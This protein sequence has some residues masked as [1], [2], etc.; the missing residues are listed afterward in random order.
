MSFVDDILRRQKELEKEH[1]HYFSPMV[2]DMFSVI[3]RQGTTRT[4]LERMKR[5]LNFL[6]GVVDYF[7]SSL[8][9]PDDKPATDDE[10]KENDQ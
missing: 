3:L 5:E 6:I 1:T 4:D 8:N 2:A 10:S 9:P 7:N